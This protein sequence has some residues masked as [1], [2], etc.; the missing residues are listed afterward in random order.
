[1]RI[2]NLSLALL[3]GCFVLA[4]CNKYVAETDQR[5]ETTL[6]RVEEYSEI[7]EMPDLPEPI[8]TVRV[9][10]DIWLG[11]SSTKITK[12]ESLPS[13]VE[14]EDG[15]TMSISEEATLPDIMQ[16]ISEMTG[17][18]IRLDDLR[19]EN[20]VPEET[21]AVKYAGKLSGLLDYLSNRYGL[22]WRY[23][24][25]VI[26]FYTQ[27]TRVFTVYALPTDSTF[28]ASMTGATMAEGGGGNATSNLS[29]NTDLKVWES[30]E[31][32]V[33]QVVGNNGKLSF[34]RVAGTITITASP[35]IV[36][37][38]AAYVANWNEKLSRQV[39]VTVQ[40]MIVNLNKTDNYGLNL[41]AAFKGSRITSG[42][43][44]AFSAVEGA[45]GGGTLNMTLLKPGKWSGT[46]AVIDALSSQGKTRL[47]TS[48]SVTTLNNKVAP[49]NISTSENYVKQV[50][51]SKTTSDGDTSTDVDFDVDTLN[52]GFTMEVL[53]R[54]LDHGRLILLFN[55]SYTELL[56]MQSA[57][58]GD[59]DSGSSSES[60]SE[61]EA[62]TIKLPKMGMR[63]FVQEIAMRS[64]QTL[65]LT[66]FERE[67]ENAMSSGIGKAQLGLLGGN[68]Y[69]TTERE[70]LVV[71]I[72]PEVL[73][74]PLTP[75]ALMRDY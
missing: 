51:V 18:T 39:A 4:S 64:G 69:N 55:L 56:D 59:T 16:E 67:K 47:V 45:V 14:K 63:G 9:Q 65:V 61:S 2:K 28:T 8:D 3:A 72:T 15:I 42:F 44:T 43:D 60:E 5:I 20:A 35:H 23:K 7:A 32:G 34:S 30:I 21:V 62:K 46:Q 40:L 19:A 66:G 1:M 11:A 41:N 70:V 68:A 27:E 25:D 48:A 49:V 54:I 37:K 6:A 33:K 52:Y 38:V 73:Q 58:G 57:S 29:V 13:W 36:S 74:S 17:L 71:T 50:T 10:N 31:E 53:P 26:T 75:E 24:D 12:G 22:Y